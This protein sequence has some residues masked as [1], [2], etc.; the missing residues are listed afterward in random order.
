PAAEVVVQDRPLGAD[1]FLIVR[2]AGARFGLPLMEV[3][4]VVDLTISAAPRAVPAR[5]R[6]LRGLLPL[7]GRF[8]SLVHLGAMIADGEPPAALGELAAVVRVGGASV[9]LEV[10]DVEAVV[11]RH[12]T[13]VG[14]APVAWARTVWRV[15]TELVTVLDLGVLAERIAGAGMS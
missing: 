13:L 14:P 11:D 4:E 3:R 15:G 10:D 5:C 9:A 1:S 12:A 8:G 2:V 6:A 7:R